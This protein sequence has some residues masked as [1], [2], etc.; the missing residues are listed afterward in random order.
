MKL[1]QLALA[2]AVAA[3]GLTSALMPS[4]ATAQAK[5]QFFPVLVYRTGAYAPNGVPWA[6]GYVDYLKPV[7]YTHLTLPTICSV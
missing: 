5:D 4:V 1:R 6:N 2:T 7:S 3:A